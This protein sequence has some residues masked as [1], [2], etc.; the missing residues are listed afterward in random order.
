MRRGRAVEAGLMP[1]WPSRAFGRQKRNILIQVS[2][3]HL[4]VG[5]E[6]LA[7]PRG[8]GGNEPAPSVHAGLLC[9]S[10]VYIGPRTKIISFENAH[11]R[12]RLRLGRIVR[13]EPRG[14][15]EGVARRRA[16]RGGLGHTCRY[17]PESAQGVSDGRLTHLVQLGQGRREEAVSPTERDRRE[18][19]TPLLPCRVFSWGLFLGAF[20]GEWGG[21]LFA[22]R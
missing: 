1:C 20:P 12:S 10:W 18:S 5:P 3:F 14:G 22:Y 13:E 9:S 6:A 4:R 15:L 17:I 7:G 2:V 21:F 19:F 16:I 11:A 8:A